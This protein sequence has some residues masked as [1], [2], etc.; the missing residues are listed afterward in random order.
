MVPGGV[1][2]SGC[3]SRDTSGVDTSDWNREEFLRRRDS[4]DFYSSG[5]LMIIPLVVDC[6]RRWRS[7]ARGRLKR[8]DGDL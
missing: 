2:T 8:S 7:V 6:R 3:I 1:D 4:G 5:K